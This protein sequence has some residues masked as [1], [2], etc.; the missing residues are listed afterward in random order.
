MC[1]CAASTI[2]SIIIATVGRHHGALG[3]PLLVLLLRLLRLLLGQLQLGPLEL[4]NQLLHLVSLLLHVL[5]LNVDPLIHVTQLVPSLHQMCLAF[6]DRRQ[7]LLVALRH[8]LAR[9]RSH[10]RS[11][12]KITLVEDYNLPRKFLQQQQQQQNLPATEYHIHTGTQALEV[13]RA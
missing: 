10:G 5:Q 4:D 12:A 9:A 3:V 2:N 13:L 1:V 11:V 7:P 6:L 8:R